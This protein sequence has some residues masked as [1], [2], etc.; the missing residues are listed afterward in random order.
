MVWAGAVA[1]SVAQTVREARQRAT[2]SLAVASVKAF[3][4]LYFCVVV[5]CGDIADTCG[6]P[7]ELSVELVV[8][9]ASMRMR[10]V[11]AAVAEGARA[12]TAVDRRGADTTLGQGAPWN[13][14]PWLL[15]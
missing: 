14:L 4:C 7:M 9:G 1:V 5:L 12:A 6:E 15:P 13:L 3:G 11:Q 10:A 2:N 8:N